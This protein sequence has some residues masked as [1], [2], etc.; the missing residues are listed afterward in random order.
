[1]IRSSAVRLGIPVRQ[2]TLRILVPFGLILFSIAVLVSI[3]ATYR[4]RERA[5]YEQQVTIKTLF[6]TQESVHSS[7][8]GLAVLGQ[9]RGYERIWVLS[10]TGDI[11]DSNKRSDIGTQLDSRWWDRLKDEESGF[12]QEQ[13]DFGNQKLSLTALHHAEMGRWVVIVSRP[14]STWTLTMLY[15][16]LILIVGLILWLL[17]AGLIWGTLSQKIATPIKKLDDRT[18]E[19]M[20]GTILTEAA[21]ERLLAETSPSLGGHAG[22]VVELARKVRFADKKSSES[23]ARFKQIFDGLSSLAFIRSPN[24]KIALSN[25]ALANRLSVDTAWIEGQSLSM[26]KGIVPVSHL[27]T[28]FSKESASKVGIDKVELFPAHNSELSDPIL[29]S[30]QPI[31]FEGSTCH[32][33]IVEEIGKEESNRQQPNVRTAEEVVANQNGS[34]DSSSLDVEVPPTLSTIRLLDGLMEATGQF[35]VV[36]NDDAKTIFWSPAAKLITGV[37]KEDMPD[38]KSFAE[39]I[40]T[41]KQERKLFKGWIDGTPDERSQ[42]LK[43]R[44][45]DGTVTSR[46]YASEIEIDQNQ[47]VGALWAQLDTNLI[48]KP[49]LK[50]EPVA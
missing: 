20:G 3:F 19:L 23:N 18:I 39:K 43:V 37:A 13:I 32:L 24:G 41:T 49:S 2:L 35:V 33:V 4:L 42:E 6:E 29:L 38:M 44:T 36:F 17:T 28:W 30:I 45:V 50:R 5:L 11:L 34:G 15:F 14:R 22:Y 47:S 9:N 10:A 16:G 27:E 7:R 26:L 12:I 46:W 40:F 8:N 1:M 48:R 21:L 25:K 31:Q